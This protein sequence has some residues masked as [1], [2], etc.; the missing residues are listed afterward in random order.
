MKTVKA[1]LPHAAHHHRSTE[2]PIN[3]C[4]IYL[5]IISG[6]LWISTELLQLVHTLIINL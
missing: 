3:F 1:P 2:A 4:I 6:N 5:Y